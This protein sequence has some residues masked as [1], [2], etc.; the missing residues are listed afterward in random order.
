MDNI[1]VSFKK[2]VSWA[3]L[4]EYETRGA[5]GCDV[6]IAIQEELVL[7][8]NEVKSLPTGFAMMIPFG[9]EAQIRSRAGMAKKGIVVANAPGTIDCE[10]V[11]E[12]KVLLLNVTDKPV[13]ILPGQKVA[14][15]V[16][17]PVA[18]AQFSEEI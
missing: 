14:Q 6:S 17:A 8:P 16:F 12:L 15:M 5:A 1:K 9:Y 18:Q 3:K 13:R 10:H 11:G 2:L 7:Y 4:P